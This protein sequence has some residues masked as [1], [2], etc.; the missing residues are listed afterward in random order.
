MCCCIRDAGNRFT[1]KQYLSKVSAIS[2]AVRLQLR[3]NSEC[4]KKDLESAT[5]ALT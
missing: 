5:G 1:V 4:F 2:V 3:Q